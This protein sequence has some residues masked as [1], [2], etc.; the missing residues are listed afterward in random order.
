[1]TETS[2]VNP[3]STA[4]TLAPTA[5]LLTLSNTELGQRINAHHDA[6]KKREKDTQKAIDDLV[7]VAQRT[8]I[9]EALKAGEYLVE[10][11]RREGHGNW[12]QWLKRH[13]KVTERTA[14]RY[15]RLKEEWPKIEE[16]CQAE[17]R[18]VA[19]LS[20]RE[21]ERL[22]EPPKPEEP[23]DDVK[24]KDDDEVVVSDPLAGIRQLEDDLVTGLKELKRDNEAKAKEAT[25]NIVRRFG[26]ADLY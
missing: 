9:E 17:K 25:A 14:Q 2:L 13:C 5:E 8:I 4:A 12:G 10:V 26:D 22:L 6:I 23:K 11:K 3:P 24:A 20:L 21:A 1:M 7:S 18:H 19:D 16:R 15:M